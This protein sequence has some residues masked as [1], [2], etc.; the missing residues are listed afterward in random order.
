MGGRGVVV[1][2]VG[3]GDGQAPRFLVTTMLLAQL[4]E[5]LQASTVSRSHVPMCAQTL[6]ALFS[7]FPFR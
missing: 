2:V 4:E 3:Y 1:G 6:F 7:P 5:L